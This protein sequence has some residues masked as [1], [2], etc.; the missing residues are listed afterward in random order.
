M[1]LD[2][3]RAFATLAKTKNI[4]RTAE[5]LHLS[6]AAIHKQLKNLQDVLEVRLYEKVGR[7]LLLTPAAQVLL[8][9][10]TDLLVRYQA[11]MSAMN[12]WKGLKTG[13]VRLGTGPGTSTCILPKLLEPFRASYPEAEVLVE[14]GSSAALMQ[15]LSESSLDVAIM[16]D[17]DPPQRELLRVE[18]AWE[19]AIVL[20]TARPQVPRDC[21]IHDLSSL[22]FILFRSGSQIEKRIDA[23]FAGHNFHPRVM[24]RFDNVETIKA[25]LKI[26]TAVAMLPVYTV[27]AEIHSGALFLIR[28]L[29]APLCSR[30]IVGVRRGGYL[31]PMASALV[32]LARRSQF[33]WLADPPVTGAYGARTPRPGRR[34]S[35]TPR[36][37]HPQHP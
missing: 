11:T 33:N 37:R 21:S 15:G 18:M 9:H 7:R 6:P 12:E 25:M 19:F 26:D 17:P 16:V 1:E 23:Y 4:T 35:R 14:N 22:P 5:A 27:E 13:I 2:G 3:L 30:I 8:P 31:P 29:E 32:D 34:H 20:V 24:M 28:Q 10:A 36:G